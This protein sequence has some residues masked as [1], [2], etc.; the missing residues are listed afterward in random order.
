MTHY[1]GAKAIVTRLGW[2]DPRRLPWLIKK[3]GLP[4]FPRRR[5]GR[6]YI[7]YYASEAMLCAWE[8]ARAKQHCEQLLAKER[9]KQEARQEALRRAGKSAGREEP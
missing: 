6:A 2:K 5:P 8:L 9:E 4:A 7:C 3:W 1:F